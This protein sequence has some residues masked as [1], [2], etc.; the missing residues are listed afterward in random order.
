MDSAQAVQNVEQMLTTGGGWQDQA[1]QPTAREVTSGSVF[2]EVGAILGG[3]KLTH[4]KASL[5]LRVVP[6]TWHIYLKLEDTSAQ[7]VR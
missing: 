2:A 7:I 1:E 4:S 5:P 6:A 3:A